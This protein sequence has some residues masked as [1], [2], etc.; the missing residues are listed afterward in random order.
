MKV[1]IVGHAADKLTPATEAKARELIRRLL[2]G[3]TVMVSGHCHLGGIDIWAEE[4]ARALGIA[5]DIKPPKRLSWSG[6]YKERNLE[7][8]AA[9][10]CVHCIV[11]DK[12]PPG[13]TGMR[14]EYCYHCKTD[15]HVKS[16]GCWTALQAI[17]VG[18]SGDV[19][20]IAS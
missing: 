17:R 19:H 9:A 7:I 13:Y 3:A 11:V 5:L 1:G 8:V 16:G 4:E 14:F 2:S 12:L 18:K 10:D 20:V 15:S 6:G